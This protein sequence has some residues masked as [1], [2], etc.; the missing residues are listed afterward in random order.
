MFSTDDTIVAIAT[1]PGRGG[2]GVVRLSGPDASRI[3]TALS[4]LEHLAPRHATLT[5]IG[6]AGLRDQ[7]ILTFFPA[8]ASYTGEDVVEISAH[9]S[10]VILR[11]IL[12]RAIASGARLAEPGEFTL[13]AY[14]HGRLDLVQAEAVRDL[15]DAVTPLQARAAFD[16]LDGTLTDRIRALDA[17]LFDV[18]TRLEASLDFAG[19]GY[20]FV[21][22][23]RLGVEIR[24]VADDIAA[25]LSDA[26]R[27][28]LVREGARVVIAGRPNAGKSTLFN[29][30]AGADRA[31]VTDIPGTTRDLV[32]EI[33]DIGGVPVTLVD[34]AGL[35]VTPSDAV[36]LEGMQRARGAMAAADLVVVLLDSSRPL[37]AED[38]ALLDVTAAMPRVVTVSKSDLPSAWTPGGEYDTAVALSVATGG[39][40][41][42]LRARILA[43]LSSG[44]PARDTPAVTNLRHV[45]L[46]ERAHA[47]LLR[48]QEAAVHATPEEF[49]AA[50][51]A[52]AREAL[53]EITG[54]RTVDDTLAAIFSKFCI[55]K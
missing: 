40:L 18:S 17:A 1:P 16:Q 39:G 12:Q 41:E 5:T 21:E 49:V 48:A 9:G 37:D 30:L 22:P 28:R 31:I 33:V 52:D 2:I 25:L 32:S 29:A 35:R 34:T 15:V 45:E 7:A 10:P 44:E 13:R 27:G 46:L 24:A 43:A 23:G 47:A 20:H 50:D 11:S 36:E 6:D 38:A 51:V 54:R 19:E 26:R 3:A 4:A 42:E 53:E 14:L 55:G 8:P